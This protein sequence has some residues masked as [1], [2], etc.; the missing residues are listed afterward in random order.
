MSI[1]ELDRPYF[2]FGLFGPDPG[3]MSSP[4][5]TIR[6]GSEMVFLYICWNEE[7]EVKVEQKGY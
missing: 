7:K 4:S 6:S 1:F 2:A 5:R 3:Q